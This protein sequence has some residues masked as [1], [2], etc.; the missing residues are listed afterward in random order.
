MRSPS[1]QRLTELGNFVDRYASVH[2]LFTEC[3]NSFEIG[4]LFLFTSSQ[5]V[6]FTFPKDSTKSLVVLNFFG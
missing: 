5:E 6:H 1:L 4:F 3:D 2:L